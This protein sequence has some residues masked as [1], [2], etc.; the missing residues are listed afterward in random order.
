MRLDPRGNIKWQ[1]TYGG[2]KSDKAKAVAIAPNG[3]VIIAGSTKSFGVFGQTVWI[4]RLDEDGR[5]KWSK[6][7]GGERWDEIYAFSIDKNGNIIA[8][9]YTENL[10]K[11]TGKRG[12]ILYLPPTGDVPGS[13]FFV[14]MWM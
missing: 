3:D 8:G 12:Y 5:I 1:Q 7:Y 13:K 10:Q 6:I 14:E 9:G 11:N 2:E 4:L